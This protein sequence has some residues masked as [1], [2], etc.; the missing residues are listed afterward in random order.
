MLCKLV[1][2]EVLSSTVGCGHQV[3][4]IG[5]PADACLR[6]QATCKP[7]TSAPFLRTLPAVR[8]R[9]RWH[10][11]AHLHTVSFSECSRHADTFRGSC[12]CSQ[13]RCNML[14]ATVASDQGTCLTSRYEKL[15][16]SVGYLV[17]LV[18]RQRCCVGSPVQPLVQTALTCV[19]LVVK[20]DQCGQSCVTTPDAQPCKCST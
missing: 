6:V 11:I 2:I 1:S 17:T 20:L 10:S 8:H 14:P 16:K 18:T 19:D 13:A 12:L 3:A 15:Q 4:S 5:A 9:F 7:V